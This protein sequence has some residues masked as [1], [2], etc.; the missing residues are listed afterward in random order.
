MDSLYSTDICVELINGTQI[1][2]SPRS[3]SVQYL[4][5]GTQVMNSPRSFYVQ[6]LVNGTQIMDSPRFSH[7]G[8]LIDTSRH[9]IGKSVIK[10]SLIQV[11]LCVPSEIRVLVLFVKVFNQCT[12][13]SLLEVYV[14][15]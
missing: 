11:Y 8:V 13:Q 2:D 14:R 7:R 9:Y 4:M 6:Y 5:N 3:V 1:M 12:D 10:V 15:S